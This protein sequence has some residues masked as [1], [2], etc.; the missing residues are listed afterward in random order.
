M[1][2]T[3]WGA[4]VLGECVRR[5]SGVGVYGALWEEELRTGTRGGGCGVSFA[6]WGTAGAEG[7]VPP[8]GAALRGAAYAHTEI[9]PPPGT[10]R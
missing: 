9:S 10:G 3:G 6:E 4:Q 2:G 7:A 8:P 5:G 1:E